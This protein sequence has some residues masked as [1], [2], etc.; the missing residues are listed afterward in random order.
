[1]FIRH[2]YEEEF[3]DTKMV[4]WNRKSKKNRQT[5]WLKEKRQK[6][7]QWYTKHYT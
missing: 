2:I 3:A 1:M 6:D 7:K 4:F 5:Q